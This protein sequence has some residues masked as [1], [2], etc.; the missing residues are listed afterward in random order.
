[1]REEH[2]SDSY[3]NTKMFFGVPVFFVGNKLAP[4]MIERKSV[5]DVAASLADGK[6]DHRKITFL[7]YWNFQN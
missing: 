7:Q 6:K 3:S 1:M 5:E 4:I 2:F